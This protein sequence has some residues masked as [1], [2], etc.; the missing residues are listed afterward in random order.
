MQFRFLLAVLVLAVLGVAVAPAPARA[1]NIVVVINGQ[2]ITEYD[3]LNRQ[4]LLAL[5]GGGRTV[6]RASVIDEL[7][8]ERLK[9]NEARKLKITVTDK[10]VDA[11]FASIAERVKLTPANLVKALAS[12]GV[13]AQT[14]RDRLRGDIA[15]QQVVQQRG[16]RA[17]NIR[18]QDVIDALKK[19]GEDPDH[20]VAFEYVM[21]QVVFF[22]KDPKNAT[23]RSQAEAFR[24][25]VNGCDNLRERA[26]NV[27]DVAI[28]DTIR[29]MAAD[30]PTGVR[31]LVEKTEVG[32]ATA[33]E[34]SPLGF[35]FVV[36]CAK[37]EVPGR[38]AAT[39]QVRNE[40][41]EQEMEQASRRLLL[42]ARQAASIDYRNH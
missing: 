31:A 6:A 9:L 32:H 10:Q 8:D 20:I 28:R 29:R 7:I 3:V 26:R 21:S 34:P 27:P 14:L 1:Q 40:L 15:W 37:R 33:V 19:K 39:Q 41:M 25:G 35:E 22:S 4:R 42:D 23:R 18:D 24:S 16:Q 30:M 11:A 13:N 2:V 5:T 38:E 36:V 12:K 17:I